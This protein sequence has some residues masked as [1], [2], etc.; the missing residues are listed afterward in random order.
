M[1]DDEFRDYILGFV[2]YKF[3]SEKMHLQEP[4]ARHEQKEN[5]TFCTEL[6]IETPL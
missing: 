2:F 6:N 5:A 4:L 3:L 1:N